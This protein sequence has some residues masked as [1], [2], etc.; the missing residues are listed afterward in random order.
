LGTAHSKLDRAIGTA[1]RRPVAFVVLIFGHRALIPRHLPNGYPIVVWIMCLKCNGR[2]KV[3][4]QGEGDRDFIGFGY[5]G[6]S[7]AA[8]QSR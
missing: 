7:P 2:G 4:V 5:R 8:N 3:R 1:R 6:G